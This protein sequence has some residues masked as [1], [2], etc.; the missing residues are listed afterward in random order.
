MPRPDACAPRFSAFV[1]GA[2]VLS[3]GLDHPEGVVYDPERNVLHAGGEDG[4]LVTLDLDGGHLSSER[5]MTGMVLGLAVDGHGDV[6]ACNPGTSSVQLV[7]DGRAAT[8]LERVG[9]RGLVTPNYPAFGPDGSLYVTDS[10]H[11][12][13]D[14]GVVVRIDADGAAEVLSDRLPHFTNG[15]AVTADG[16]WLWVIESLGPTVSRIDLRDGGAPET[17]V[18]LPDTVPDGL[19]FTADGG[20]LISCYRPDR[21]YH[22][23]A[24]G[25]L[26]ILAE[27]P[28]GTLLAAPTNVCFAGP[29]RDRLVVANLGRWH[30]TMLDVALVGVDP[31]RPTRWAGSRERPDAD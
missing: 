12:E 25:V 4:Q 9:G 30:L 21:I 18:Q 5:P 16:R 24:S 7:R 22:L 27:D 11:W 17:V 1:G 29:R 23:A 19:A 26:S 3:E 20:V 13:H 10:G 6:V 31:H 2:R 14:D 15:C 8:L 28:A